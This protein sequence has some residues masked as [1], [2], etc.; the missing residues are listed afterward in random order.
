MGM[1]LFMSKFLPDL[2]KYRVEA[3]V[4]I[5]MRNKNFLNFEH[6][7]TQLSSQSFFIALNK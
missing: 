3:P 7:I 1:H 2:L 5:A 6:P 4:K